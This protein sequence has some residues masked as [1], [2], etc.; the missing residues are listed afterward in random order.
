MRRSKATRPV[1]RDADFESFFEQLDPRAIRTA[2]RILGNQAA[3]EDVAAEALARA[4][5]RWGQV[6][7]LS[8]RDG[9]VLRT[10]T[11][12]AID[13]VRRKK[14]QLDPVQNAQ[15]TEIATLRMA[16][17]AALKSLPKRQREAIALRY[18][19]GMSDEEVAATLGVESGTVRTHIHRGL[20]RL[21]SQ[22]G[23]RWEG[24]EVAFDG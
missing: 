5:S 24:A 15:D 7:Q 4:F 2:H 18:L 10:A 17:V 1:R 11:N 22:I 21:R 9:W 14:P 6:S 3:A 20:S 8:Y 16:L 23:D 13:V 19:S 12:L